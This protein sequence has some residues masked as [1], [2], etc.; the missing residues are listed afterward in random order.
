MSEIIYERPNLS[1]TT[2]TGGALIDSNRFAFLLFLG[3]DVMLFA[4]LIGGYIVLKGNAMTWPPPGS[5]GLN[6]ALMLWTCPL[7]LGTWVALFLA[8]KSEAKGQ[9]DRSRTLLIVGLGSL[10]GFIALTMIEWARMLNEGLAIK[11]IFGGIYLIDT[12]TFVLQAGIGMIFIAT[13]IGKL[14]SS[15]NRI[16]HLSYYF[17]VLACVWMTIFGLVYA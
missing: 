17:F 14:G 10:A 6:Q 9:I 3:V 12:G 1:D 13:S 8:S 5:P 2:H 11:T 15:P 4:G 7:I 16:T